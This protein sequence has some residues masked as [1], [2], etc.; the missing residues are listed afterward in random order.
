MQ[1]QMDQQKMPRT[2]TMNVLCAPS[3]MIN[4][5]RPKIPKPQKKRLHAHAT[6]ISISLLALASHLRWPPEVDWGD[7]SEPRFVRRLP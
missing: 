3:V 2:A 6:A 5:I 7:A 1:R 4:E